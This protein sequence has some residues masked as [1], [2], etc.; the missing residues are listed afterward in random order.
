MLIALLALSNTIQGPTQSFA[1]T[2]ASGPTNRPSISSPIQPCQPLDVV[3]P[4]MTG[5]EELQ[6][7]GN[8]KSTVLSASFTSVWTIALSVVGITVLLQTVGESP[9]FPAPVRQALRA[10][11]AI[12]SRNDQLF[13]TV[14]AFCKLSF[15]VAKGPQLERR[16][17]KKTGF[18]LFPARP[19]MYSASDVLS[20]CI[21]A[22]CKPPAEASISTS[23]VCDA[24]ALKMRVR[25][26]LR[27]VRQRARRVG[28]CSAKAC[29]LE[30]Q[31]CP[32]DNEDSGEIPLTSAGSGIQS[33]RGGSQPP[34]TK[35]AWHGSVDIDHRRILR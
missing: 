32:Y 2:S 18:A 9:L 19:G 35:M 5:T 12:R 7:A 1:P 30:R 16:L 11:S 8:S 29:A 31:S 24:A 15:I 25:R 23:E 28:A 22:Q 13:T 4:K 33:L 10:W 3:A 27:G 21:S 17:S 26:R 14:S 34:P 20:Q 6:E